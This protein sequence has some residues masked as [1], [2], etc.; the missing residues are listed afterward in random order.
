MENL[1]KVVDDILK[2]ITDLGND[3]ATDVYMKAALMA[4][5][6]LH[7]QKAPEEIMLKFTTK[8]C[9]AEIITLFRMYF[10]ENEDIKEFI[11]KEFPEILESEELFDAYFGEA[12]QNALK[13]A[14]KTGNWDFY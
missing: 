10:P 3:S 11:E 13:E 12:A 2:S 1:I 14:I 8:H 5:Y 9:T 7:E 6:A 4:A